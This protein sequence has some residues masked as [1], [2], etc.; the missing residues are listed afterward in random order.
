MFGYPDLDPG[1]YTLRVGGD[2]AFPIG[3]IGR[4]LL[5]LVYATSGQMI[6]P[7]LNFITYFA[8]RKLMS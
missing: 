6:K 1:L 4:G 2:V 7:P 5:S 3:E 8:P